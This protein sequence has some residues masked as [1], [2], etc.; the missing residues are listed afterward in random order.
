MKATLE[1]D[2]SDT[3]DKIDHMMC[4]KSKDAFSALFAIDEYFRRKYKHQETNDL[5]MAEFEDTKRA[6]YDIMYLE[7]NLELD[8]IYR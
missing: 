8:E 5:A 2:L 7:N 3:S 6:V 1:F 4:I